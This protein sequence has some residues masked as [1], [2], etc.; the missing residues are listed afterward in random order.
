MHRKFKTF[1]SKIIRPDDCNISNEAALDAA[2][3]MY[4]LEVSGG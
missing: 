4:N 2:S 1:Q 3:E